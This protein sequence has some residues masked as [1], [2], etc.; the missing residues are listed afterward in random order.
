VGGIGDDSNSTTTENSIADSELY[1]D[2]YE[3]MYSS[4]FCLVLFQTL[5]GGNSSGDGPQF[6]ATKVTDKYSM[7]G[8]DMDNI[9]DDLEIASILKEDRVEVMST[10]T[11][12]ELSELQGGERGSV[13]GVFMDKTPSVGKRASRP[14]AQVKKTMDI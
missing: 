14:R 1:E 2:L 10:V 8:P 11:D 3:E 9:I 13:K 6:D 4:R 12:S 5:G 7:R